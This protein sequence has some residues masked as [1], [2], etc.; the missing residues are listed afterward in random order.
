MSDRDRFIADLV[1]ALKENEKEETAERTG[2]NNALLLVQS[3]R[4]LLFDAP[5]RVRPDALQHLCHALLDTSTCSST[6]ISL[7]LSNRFVAGVQ[8]SLDYPQNDDEQ[9]E[10]YYAMLHCTIHLLVPLKICCAPSLQQ[11]NLYL[12]SYQPQATTTTRPLDDLS[13]DVVDDKDAVDSN[14]H[15]NKT[16]DND[17]D[18]LVERFA[19]ESDDDDFAFESERFATPSD[20]PRIDPLDPVALSQPTTRT[21][22]NV[23][24]CV[25][26]LLQSVS[27]SALSRLSQSQWK[28]HQLFERL[29]QLIVALFTATTTASGTLWDFGVCGW[30]HT[31]VKIVDAYRD[32]CLQQTSSSIGT[33]NK[34]FV[35]EPFLELTRVLLTLKTTTT[36]TQFVKGNMEPATWVGLSSLSTLAVELRRTTR[37]DKNNNHSEF[38]ALVHDSILDSCDQLTIVLEQQQQ[39]TTTTDNSAAVL[40]TFVPLFQCLA[41][42]GSSHTAQTMLQSGLFRQ[43]LVCWKET[44]TLK[45]ALQ[46]SLWELCL[47]SPSISGKYAWRFMDF[48]A[49]VTTFH[50]A[51]TEEEP[52]EQSMLRPFLW[53]L[54]GIHLAGASPSA[55]TLVRLN[56]NPSAEKNR[57][58]SVETCR[59]NAGRAFELVFDQALVVVMDWKQRRQKGLDLCHVEVQ[60]QLLDDVTVLTTKLQ[61]PLV[62]RLV[63]DHLAV[64]NIV[65]RLKAIQ[66]ALLQWPTIPAVDAD[67]TSTETDGRRAFSETATIND[68]RKAVKTL[69]SLLEPS[70]PHHSFS[71][72]AD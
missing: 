66:Q 64:E 7:K 31:A 52:P 27:I 36:T 17:D 70:L 14:H 23:G 46:D 5:E 48:A 49:C 24:G 43:W 19:A 28:E 60:K 1:A 50:E 25:Y 8:Q 40:W 18:S 22:R 57:I 4:T 44:E 63:K 6:S 53:N 56:K 51:S 59:T 67:A 12:G 39:K 68:L 20:D 47:A 35:L 16:V 33:T 54:L 37:D 15:H 11:A 34:A 30:Q 58:V 41:T 2:P 61:L 45:E 26:D 38:Y 29:T 21:W 55:G 9:H 69:Q 13:N 71:S 3:Y 10:R 62:N 65:E 72:K 42:N 32:V